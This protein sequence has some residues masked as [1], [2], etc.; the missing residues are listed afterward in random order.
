MYKWILTHKKVIWLL[1]VSSHHHS[2]IK[3]KVLSTNTDVYKFK[4]ENV[5]N[6]KNISKLV[7][8]IW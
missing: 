2:T 7:P 8:S 6:A 4:L 5:P 1:L 3:E